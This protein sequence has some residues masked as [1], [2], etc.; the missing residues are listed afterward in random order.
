METSSKY[1]LGIQR[2]T[3]SRRAQV[4]FFGVYIASTEGKSDVFITC[5]L[6]GHGASEVAEGS[7]GTDRNLGQ[8]DLAASSASLYQK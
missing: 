1:E 7:F 2:Y 5:I 8:S 4:H 6:C 3:A